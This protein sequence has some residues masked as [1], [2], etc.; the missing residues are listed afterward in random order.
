M[1]EEKGIVKKDAG[2]KCIFLPAKK[3]KKQKKKKK[4]AKPPAPEPPLM[5]VKSDGGYGYDT[6]DMA[7][8]W[9][10]L[11]DQKSKRVIYITDS[12]QGT[13]FARIFQAAELM[14]WHKPGTTRME[15]MPFGLV[16]D[17]KGQKFSTRSGD[18]VKLLS[19]LDTARDKA[20][21]LILKKEG[22]CLK[23]PEKKKPVKLENPDAKS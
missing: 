11:I 8:A 9:Y 4:K 3:S 20:L 12:G 6:T 17:E 15:H 16:Q 13:H 21:E 7:A 23:I 5:L 2:A 22:L 10:R 19:L 14:G 18:T 1:A